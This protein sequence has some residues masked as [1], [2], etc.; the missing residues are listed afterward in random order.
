MV[1]SWKRIRNMMLN[2]GPQHPAAHGVMRLVLHL[3][4]E[5]VERVDP[6]IGLLHRGTEKL[7]EYKTYLQGLPYFDRLDY[8]SCMAQ[9]LA[10]SLAVEKLID[11]EVPLRGKYIRVL[12]CE[13]TRLLNHL[14]ALTTHAL[15]VGAMSPFLWGFEEREK[16]LEF[17]ERVS[18]ARFHSC[19]IRPGGV[20][21]EVTSEL[22]KSIKRFSH[23]FMDRLE[24]MEEVLTSNRIWKERLVDIGCVT[25]QEAL[26]YGFSGVMLRCTGVPWD[27]RASNPYDVYERIKWNIPVSSNGDCYDRYMLRFYEMRESLRI[28][29]ECVVWLEMVKGTKYFKDYNI[30]NDVKVD[31]WK[32]SPPFRSD[33]EDDMEAL[34][35]HFKY[36]S[37]GVSPFQEE[38]YSV[39]ESPKGEFGV[40]LYSE[41]INIPYRCRIKAP[42]FLHLQGISKLVEG[43]MLAD[44]VTVIGT[45]DLVFGEVDR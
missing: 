45:L 8:V 3:D 22:L 25:F 19:F 16:I 21:M 33:M 1:G 17:C 2:F 42:G 37:E 31:D 6:H 23:M 29:I 15:D 27:L 20:S 43:H 9:E 26:D 5:V 41:G 24:E 18:G 30:F 14:L 7:M 28:I 35:H 32:V 44:L 10:Y 12:F 11:C 34:I 4:G 36:Y 13:L 38:V 39:I 40:Y